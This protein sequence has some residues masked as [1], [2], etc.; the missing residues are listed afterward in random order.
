VEHHADNLA[1]AYATL[2]LRPG[3]SARDLK[4]QYRKLIKRWHPDR[5]ATDPQGQLEA[6][7]QMS[8][9]NQAFGLV[10]ESMA[11]SARPA[12]RDAGRTAERPRPSVDFGSR[13]LTKSEIDEIVRAIG[14]TNPVLATFRMLAWFVPLAFAYVVVQGHGKVISGNYVPPTTR[15]WILGGVFS[16]IGLTILV[17]QRW[18]GPK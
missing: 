9:I 3:C 18:V 16:A 1:R 2:G 6:A 13:P 5:Y 17:R 15:D 7:Q 12:R 4:A 10:A 8:R 14:N 11:A